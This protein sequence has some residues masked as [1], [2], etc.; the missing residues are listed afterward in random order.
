MSQLGCTVAEII[1]RLKII[2]KNMKMMIIMCTILI[3]IAMTS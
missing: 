2:I 3:E 1:D